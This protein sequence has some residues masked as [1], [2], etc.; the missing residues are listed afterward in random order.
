MTEKELWGYF[1]KKVN[2]IV[3]NFDFDNKAR[4]I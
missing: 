1:G 2:Y 4:P 3:K